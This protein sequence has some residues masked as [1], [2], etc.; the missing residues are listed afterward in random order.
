MNNNKE[1][2]KNIDR[3]NLN[4]KNKENTDDNAEKESLK[5]IFLE[6]IFLQITTAKSYEVSNNFFSEINIDQYGNCFYLNLDY[7]Y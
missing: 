3:S 1:T 2:S 5:R 6:E 7:I 4:T